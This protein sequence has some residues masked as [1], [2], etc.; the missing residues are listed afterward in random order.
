MSVAFEI[1]PTPFAEGGGLWR[2]LGQKG[3]NCGGSFFMREK[4]GLVGSH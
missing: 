4:K 2:V 1:P 3:G